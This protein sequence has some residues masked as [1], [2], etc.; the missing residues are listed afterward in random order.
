MR[1][2]RWPLAQSLVDSRSL[3]GHALLFCG[4]WTGGR[5]C[6]LSVP[7]PWEEKGC[8]PGSATQIW[9]WEEP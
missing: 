5:L 7:E 2:G 8:M 9:W 3:E 1:G 4:V 6:V